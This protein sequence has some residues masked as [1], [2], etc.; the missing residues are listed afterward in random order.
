MTLSTSKS[1]VSI[2]N[3]LDF[4]QFGC[5]NNCKCKSLFSR[6]FRCMRQVIS[7]THCH[8]I[9][10]HLRCFFCSCVFMQNCRRPSFSNEKTHENPGFVGY[11]P[12][13]FDSDKEKW[14][15]DFPVY[16]CSDQ[17]EH[18]FQQFC[19]YFSQVVVSLVRHCE[20]TFFLPFSSRFS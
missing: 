16:L 12:W 9:L 10:H 17:C 6:D 15:R 4:F 13:C 11:L 3:F 20:R 14:Q 8:I 2:R 18:H 5:T 19:N 7:V 1:F